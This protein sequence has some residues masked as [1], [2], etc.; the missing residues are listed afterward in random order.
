MENNSEKKPCAVQKIETSQGFS[1]SYNNVFLYSKY[2]PSKNIITTIERLNLLPGTIILCCSPLL[3]YGLSELLQKLPE[4][5]LIVLCEADKVLYDFT[6][7][8]GTFNQAD[9]RVLCTSPDKLDDL[10]VMLYEKAVSGIYKRV[11]R[12]DMSAGI[13]LHNDYYDKLFA[14]C[15]DS[16]MTFWKN[17]IT[18]TKFGRRY[19]KNLFENLKNLAESIPIKDFFEVLYAG[20]ANATTVA[21]EFKEYVNKL[22]ERAPRDDATCAVI[23]VRKRTQVNVVYGPPSNAEDEK[24]IMSLFFSKGGKHVVCGGTTAKVVAKYL[25]KEIEMIDSVPGSD[26]PPMERIDG[27]DLVTEGIIT[28]GKIK[29]YAEDFLEDNILYQEWGFKKDPASI[30][31]RLLFEEATD[32]DFYIGKAVNPAHQDDKSEINFSVKMSIIQDVIEAL[33]KMG[34]NVKSNYF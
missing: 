28:M 32:I 2:N 11:T 5:C 25:E 20:G 26:V 18:L 4:N 15:S 31:A 22:Y 29:E 13:Q 7:T 33:K 10:P 1:V 23:K 9:K 19:S 34:K 30:L 21:N 16:V 3:G 12:L 14:A 24:R 8:E 17:R 6:N 27:V